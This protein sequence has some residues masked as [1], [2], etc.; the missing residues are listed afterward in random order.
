MVFGIKNNSEKDR[1][2]TKFMKSLQTT[3]PRLEFG[4]HTC[5]V[6]G[7]EKCA[8]SYM[9]LHSCNNFQVSTKQIFWKEIT[10]SAPQ[11]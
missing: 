4:Y 3:K 9:N 11:K 8:G 6:H 2:K 7:I 1:V 10:P 5:P